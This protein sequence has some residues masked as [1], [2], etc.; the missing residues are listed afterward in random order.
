MDESLTRPAAV[1]GQ[2]SA[3]QAG[4][5]YVSDREF[6]IT[7]KKSGRTFTYFNRGR[8]LKNS[9]ALKRITKL[10]IPPAWTNA[11]VC[12][13]PRGHLQA[14]GWD[15]RGRKQ[16]RYHPHWRE[17]RDENKFDRMLD[18]GKTLPKIRRAVRRR[19]R[20]PGLSREKVLAAIVR[21]LDLSAARVGNET[22]AV[23]NNSYGLTT[24]RDRHAKVS[25][26][27][28]YLRFTGKSG[29]EQRF[30][31]EHPVLARVV[32]KCQ[33]LPGQRLFQY[34][35]NGRQYNVT[36]DAVNDYLVELTGRDFTAKDFRTWAGTVIAMSVLQ[37]F[38]PA[39]SRRARQKNIVE[40][41]KLVAEELGNTAA[42][43]KRCYIHPALLEDYLKGT[44]PVT[45]DTRRAAQ[46]TRGPLRAEERLVIAWLKRMKG[47]T[48]QRRTLG[49]K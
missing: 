40:T 28:L 33:D 7:R 6:T 17:V 49:S 35:E 39:A 24:L 48:R 32:R 21:L 27:R 42:V 29:K 22:Y 2:E 25:G 30:A 8:E 43:C 45:L 13:D 14:V 41:V 44:L 9:Q 47:E 38:E 11:R 36:S 26:A 37:R 10:V 23:Q 19:M 46:S 12:A 15:V 1:I 4:L 5:R 34:V 18:F 3:K 31:I 20:Q 16:Y